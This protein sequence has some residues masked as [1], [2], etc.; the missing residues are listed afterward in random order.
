MLKLLFPP[1]C[2]LCRRVLTHAQADLCPECAKS[3]PFFTKEKIKLS[4]IARWTSVWYYKDDVRQSLLR[5]KFGRQ[6]AYAQSYSRLLAQK[7]RQTGMDKADALV[8][9]PISRLRKWRRGFDQVELLAQNLSRELD[10]PALPVLKKVRHTPPQSRLKYA[11]QR[12]ANVLG[13]Y[14]VTDPQTVRGKR[15][16]LLDDILTTGATV[17]EC[18]R[19]LTQ[20]GPVQILCATMA[21]A[22]H[23]KKNSK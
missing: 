17:T 5:Y 11:A 13:A 3:A 6:R 8:W 18:A 16:L 7:L 2:P 10:I 20:A 14:A 21:V 9:V 4:F 15:L 12:R 22:P 19:V 1:K 23:D